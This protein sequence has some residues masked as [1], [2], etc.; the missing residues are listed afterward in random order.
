MA[1]AGKHLYEFGQY[2]IDSVERLLL[3]GEETIPLTPKAI[4]TLLV[5]V[6]NSG[7][8]VEKDELMKSVWP[9]T[10]VEEGALARNV[11]ALRKALGDDIEDFHYIETI[12]KRGYRFVAPVKDLAAAVLVQS[13]DK[14]R[15]KRQ[16]RL[17]RTAW[18][19]PAVVLILAGVLAYPWFTRR[20]RSS[21]SIASLAVLPLDNP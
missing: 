12:P 20:F 8:V 5:L 15:K 4:E 21:P 6:A 16:T 3:R 18:L 17:I 19:V 1:N 7:R 13:D 14:A 9:D 11:S 2:R 10:F